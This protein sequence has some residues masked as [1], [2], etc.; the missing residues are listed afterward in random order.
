VVANPLSQTTEL[1][2]AS[3]DLRAVVNGL[4]RRVTF[5]H[6]AAGRRL[7]TTDPLGHRTQV[8]YTPLNLVAAVTDARN[9]QT[10]FTYDG[11]GNLLTLTDPRS[12]VTTYTYDVMDRV[13]TRT[14]PVNQ[15]ESYL[16]DANGNL[17]QITDREGQVTAFT[18]DALD[19]LATAT[20]HDSSTA[21]Y[22]YDAGDRL[23][24]IVDTAAGTITR[25]YDDL[26]RLTSE[27]TAEGTVSY[28]YD[29]AGRRTTMTAS[30]QLPVGYGYDAA[31][32]LTS[33][34]QGTSTVTLAYDLAGRR[35]SLVLPNGIT[36]TYGYDAADQVT[37]LTWTTSGG[38]LGDLTYAYDAAGRRTGVGGSFSRTSIPPAL[39][40]ASYD[41]ANRIQTWGGQAFSYDLNG[42]L[43]S[44][45]S[46]TFTWNVRDQLTAV[47]GGSPG[48]FTYDALGRR[49]TRTVG[50]V[51]T[52]YLYDLLDAVQEQVGGSA[53]AH[54]L[55][56]QGIDERFARNDSTGTSWY[57]LDPLQ[58][59]IALTDGAGTV[60][61]SYTYEPFGTTAQA[62]AA[63]ANPARYTG[64]E[65][66]GTG[67]YYYRT[68]YYDPRV[69]RFVSEDP[70]AFGGGGPNLYA[71]VSDNPVS[72]RD[73]LGL[74]RDPGGSGV[75][76]CV[77][78]YIPGVTVVGAGKG[79]WR[80]PEANG[81]GTFRVR[82][83]INAD[84]TFRSEAGVSES[85]IPGAPSLD[86]SLEGCDVTVKT[87][88]LA[89]RKTRAR[90][91]GLNG[92]GVP[93]WPLSFD[94]SFIEYADGTTKVTSA[95]GTVFPSYEI[96]QYGGP[97]G[98]RPVYIYNTSGTVWDLRK[99]VRTLP[100]R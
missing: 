66:D 89:G 1:E 23:L 9:G 4:G 40:A 94:F 87:M 61:T 45:G 81:D 32:Q 51:T 28:T 83:S 36:T 34:T 76:Y 93:P 50:G 59:T 16:Y 88:P 72:Y 85:W 98:P 54:Y 74:C 82:Q 33:V 26:D 62:G 67:L 7:S 99:G 31:H 15:A 97:D 20:Y 19:R 18:Y 86:G 39:T 78:A 70:I 53:S 5:E 17:Q 56:G 90:C 14:D 24:Q 2:Y 96:W 55:L 27:T 37:S 95:N 68:R 21:T 3:G 65:D 57:L 42:N 30:G 75:R 41:L 25:T 69:A 10:S 38:P 49:R 60:Q 100:K 79:D 48:T 44:D 80:G 71:Y 47:G 12:A 52:S 35:S 8:T 29:A 73:A 13:A 91:T 92:F 64:R 77:D 58:S 11:N 84:G 6:D 43:T 22:T 63:N 46:A